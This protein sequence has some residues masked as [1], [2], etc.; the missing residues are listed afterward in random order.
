MSTDGAGP[1]RAR[2]VYG[3]VGLAYGTLRGQNSFTGFSQSRTDIGWTV[4]AGMEV[5]LN[6]NWSA[7]AEYLYI[8]LNDRSHSV[9][10][11]DN[12]LESSLLRFGINYRF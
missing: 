2:A 5:A 7:R 11:T 4:G 1:V 12:G 10:G 3:T 6:S 8:D 9:T